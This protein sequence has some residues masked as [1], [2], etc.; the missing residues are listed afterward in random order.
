MKDFNTKIT[1]GQRVWL[2]ITVEDLPTRCE[3]FIVAQVAPFKV[4][5]VSL[6]TGNRWEEP[7]KVENPCDV[8]SREWEKISSIWNDNYEWTSG[9]LIRVPA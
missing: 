7:I 3:E 2:R 5:L 1:V 6:E 4:C 9:P 8:T